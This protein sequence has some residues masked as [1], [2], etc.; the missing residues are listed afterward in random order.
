MAGI[1][2]RP[3]RSDK[4]ATSDKRVGA[5]RGRSQ[6]PA[7]GLGNAPSSDRGWPSYARS[8]LPVPGSAWTHCGPS[9]AVGSNRKEL[10]SSVSRRDPWGAGAGHPKQGLELLLRVVPVDVASIPGPVSGGLLPLTREPSQSPGFAPL[11]C[12]RYHLRLPRMAMRTGSWNRARLLP[13]LPSFPG[14]KALNTGTFAPSSGSQR[15]V[16][17]RCTG[18]QRIGQGAHR[19]P[20][21][22]CILPLWD[23]RQRSLRER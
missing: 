7:T 10:C 14:G 2:E 20:C 23:I 1:G 18:I 3:A 11:L 22:F 16:F 17:G 5:A 8:R 19:A 6:A 4:Q 12:S 21:C 13:L 9:I 15:Q